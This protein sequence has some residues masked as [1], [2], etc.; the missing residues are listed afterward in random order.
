[1]SVMETNNTSPVEME[2]D[3]E[4]AEIQ[5]PTGA[6]FTS[7]FGEGASVLASSSGIASAL[8]VSLHPLVIMNIS[9]H[10][11]RT[12]AQSEFSANNQIVGA[13]IGKQKGRNV[14][15]MNSFELKFDLIDNQVTIDNDY[16]KLKEGQFKQVFADMEI[17]GWY[18]NGDIPS[19]NDLKI[20]R[21]LIQFNESLLFLKLN[22]LVLYNNC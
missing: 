10:W 20:H 21:Q 22:P 18:K 12:R 6:P 1:M 15:I 7:N 19:E 5:Q 3:G 4:Q 13:L 17:L 8:L 11:T 16:Y 2:V 9:E 14:E